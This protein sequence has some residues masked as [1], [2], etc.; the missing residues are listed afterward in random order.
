MLVEIK[1]FTNWVL[2][3]SPGTYTWESYNPDLRL[4]VR[5]YKMSKLCPRNPQVE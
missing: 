5:M 1:R 2:R 3:R 4:A